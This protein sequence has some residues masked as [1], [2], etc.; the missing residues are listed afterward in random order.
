MTLRDERHRLA[1]PDAVAGRA[2]LSLS[3]SEAHRVAFAAFDGGGTVAF[4]ADFETL[5]ENAKASAACAA[6]VVIA[7]GDEI[8][9]GASSLLDGKSLFSG[10][11]SPRG[12]AHWDDACAALRASRP[13]AAPN[14]FAAS[15]HSPAWRADGLCSG[16]GKRRLHSKRTTM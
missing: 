16:R 11:A 5:F 9:D 12:F 15:R 2:G 7:E 3:Y 8:L 14:A 13:S 6:C 4:R 1:L 10:G